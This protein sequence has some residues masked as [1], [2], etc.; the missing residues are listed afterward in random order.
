MVV[1]NDANFRGEN[2]SINGS[3]SDLSAR[4]LNSNRNKNWNNRI[5]SIQINEEISFAF[6]CLRR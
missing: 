2:V 6:S 1:Y 3:V 5:S 4:R